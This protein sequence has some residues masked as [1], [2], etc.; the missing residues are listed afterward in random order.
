MLRVLAPK[1]GPLT[2]ILKEV[3]VPT[4]VVPAPESMLAGSQQ[5]GYRW[6][7]PFA[8]SGLVKWSR[9]LAKHRF[10]TTSDAVYSIGFKAHLAAALAKKHPL[11]WHLHEYPPEASRWVWRFLARKLPSRVIV[12]SESAGREWEKGKGEKGKV[13]REAGSGEREASHPTG[14]PPYRPTARG[15]GRLVV[16]RN[17]VDLDRFKPRERTGWI[18]GE[19]GIPRNHRLIGMPA[20]LTRW[21]GQMEVIEAFRPL[22]DRF[23]DVHVVLV[24]G[25]I[26]DTVAEREYEGELLQAIGKGEK[27]KGKST[28]TEG[29]FPFP[30]SRFPRIHL[31]P[32]QSKIELA[33]PEFDLV[34]H[35]SL[36]PEPFGRVIVEAMA[37]G[38]PVI[39]AAEGGPV[40]ILGEGSG[41][42]RQGGGGWLAEPRSPSALART[43]VEVLT[44]PT[45][46]LR[47][48][49]R[50]GRIRTEDHFSARR[51]AAEVAG[52]LR[53]VGRRQ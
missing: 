15:G 31:L 6:S 34:V 25:S 5:R 53:E 51:F 16:V 9:R 29:R 11:V 35:Y 36:R 49:G 32:F 43:L 47:R 18:H 38:V 30:V 21:K 12:N 37:C 46:E 17:G 22:R 1:A 8:L 39:A 23:Q 45:E 4:E 14:L 33:Y 28:S 10:W 24:G 13:E 2:E 40:E 48:V 52:V 50:A 20:V 42:L 27:G 26:Y 44:L 19:L 3:G 7:I 41:S